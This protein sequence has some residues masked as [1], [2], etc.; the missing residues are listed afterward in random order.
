M[1]TP[2]SLIGEAHFYKREFDEAA[3]AAA[4]VDPEPSRFPHSFPRSRRC[5]A[6]MGR[7][8]DARA[9]RR[10]AARDY[11][12]IVPA[13]HQRANPT[14]RE[15]FHCRGFAS[16]QVKRNDR[17]PLPRRRKSR[18]DSAAPDALGRACRRAASSDGDKIGNRRTSDPAAADPIARSGVRSGQQ[19]DL[20]LRCPLTPTWVDDFRGD[21]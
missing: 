6:Q 11:P 18:M 3:A 4:P 19:A 20:I 2:L 12:Q 7:L 1:G 5:Y 21:Q 10:A 9:N 14:D 13:R 8:D 15:L 17:D 16:R